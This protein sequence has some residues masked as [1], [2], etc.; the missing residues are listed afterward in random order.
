MR[1]AVVLLTLVGCSATSEDDA[2]AMSGT[3]TAQY[4]MRDGEADTEDHDLFG[5]ASV[6][7]GDVED[8]G[9]EASLLA[10][11]NR[12][13]DAN[14]ASI[15]GGLSDAEGGST[16]F[17]IYHLWVDLPVGEKLEP[18]R[19]GRQ[20]EPG[21]P[22][23]AWF[24]GARLATRARGER[25][26]EYGVYAGQPVRLYESSSGDLTGGAWVA[27]QPWE[28]A[29]ARLDVMRLEDEVN[30]GTRRDDLVGLDLRQRAGEAL[31]LD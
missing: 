20:I 27:A 14:D 10:R 11:V 30:L 8:N 29:R 1:R 7:A 28:G 13:L 18:L 12:D 15:F 3:L 26:W 22:E 19:L 4:R 9:W 21:T 16:D 25:R 24:D 5:V 31:F 2:P 23:S 17:D 6:R